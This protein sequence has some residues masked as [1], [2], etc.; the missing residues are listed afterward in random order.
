MTLTRAMLAADFIGKWHA[1]DLTERAAAR[2]HFRDL[3]EL[4]GEQAPTDADP[5]GEWY[6]FEERRHQNHRRRRLGRC[7]ET[8]PLRLG[9]Q[10]QGERPTS[11]L[12]AA[13]ALCAGARKPALADHLRSRTVRDPHELDEHSQPYLRD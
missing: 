6:A 8:R 12:R 3:C 7:V 1:A 10:K 2:S 4:L 11:G 13:A 5:K 9:V